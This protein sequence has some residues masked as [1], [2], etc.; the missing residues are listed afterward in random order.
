MKKSALAA[1]AALILASFPIMLY[2]APEP[3]VITGTQVNFR[4]E[5]GTAG[6]VIGKLNRPERVTILGW[7]NVGSDRWYEISTASGTRGYVSAAFAVYESVQKAEPWK[8]DANDEGKIIISTGGREVF[9]DTFDPAGGPKKLRY[10][11]EKKLLDNYLFVNVVI[12]EYQRPCTLLFNVVKK[13]AVIKLKNLEMA[14]ASI[15]PSKRFIAV[16]S[17]S[18]VRD[19]IVVDLSNGKQ[20]LK[21]QCYAE[22]PSWNGRGG[23]EYFENMGPSVPGKKDLTNEGKVY[24]QKLVWDGSRVIRTQEHKEVIMGP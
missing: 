22:A 1:L 24:A 5:P 8:V 19:I 21:A 4:Q 7:L 6:R 14:D 15:S 10:D 13:T 20:A 18:I 3:G 11:I 16:T 23:L 12:S 2:A 17:G 9:R